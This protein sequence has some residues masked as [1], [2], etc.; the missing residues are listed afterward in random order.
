MSGALPFVGPALSLVAAK[1]ATEIGRFNQSVAN[2]NALIAKQEADQIS[3]LKT[4]NINKFNQSF[5]N[6]QSTTKVR[7]LK[8]GVELSGTALKILQSN[9]EQAELQRGIIEY[10]ANV[11]ASKKLEEANFAFISG[12]IARRRGDL[13]AIGYASQAGTSLLQMRQVG[14]V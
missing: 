3:K 14:L 2:R 1:Q 9:V 7:L 6:L 12:Q 13:A 10:N 5:E 8:S 4:Y 11:A